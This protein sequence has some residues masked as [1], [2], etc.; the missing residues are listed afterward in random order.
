MRL[1]LDELDHNK[2]PNLNTNDLISL[3]DTNGKCNIHFTGNVV[4]A[5]GMT[6]IL[7]NSALK[8]LSCK[9]YAFKK[10]IDN[11]ILPEFNTFVFVDNDMIHLNGIIM[12]FKEMKATGRLNKD[13]KL[14]AI[15][16]P[17]TPVVNKQD[18]CNAY[19]L[20]KCIMKRN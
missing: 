5:G 9:G 16:Y 4:L 13:V 6:F 12:K 8:P 1:F 14:L 18:D 19:D 7:E 17:Q 10:L 2:L 15:Y 11:N 20:D 3:I